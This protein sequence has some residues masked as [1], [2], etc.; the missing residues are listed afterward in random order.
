MSDLGAGRLRSDA[1]VGSVLALAMQYGV[2]PG[3]GS[4]IEPLLLIVAGACAGGLLIALT[5][6]LVTRAR[7]AIHARRAARRRLRA[8]AT[9]ETRA[10]ALMSELC[11]YGWHARIT[12]LEGAIDPDGNVAGGAGPGSRLTGRSSAP[13]RDARP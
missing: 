4:L 6:F 12:L 3:P 1:I 2:H 8:A 9:A 10:R 7:T 5:R 13:R 11:P